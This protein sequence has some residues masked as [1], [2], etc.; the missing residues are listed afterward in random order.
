M[1]KDKD[2]AGNCFRK[3]S[4]R[5]SGREEPGREEPGR[6]EPVRE[7]PVREEPGREEPDCGGRE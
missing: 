7:E 1:S 5:W 6:E 4:E 3:I 2:R